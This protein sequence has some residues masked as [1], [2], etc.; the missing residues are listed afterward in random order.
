M[1]I[2]NYRS[3]VFNAAKLFLQAHVVKLFVDED[4]YNELHLLICQPPSGMHIIVHGNSSKYVCPLLCQCLWIFKLILLI[5]VLIAF[6]GQHICDGLLFN[7]KLK[8]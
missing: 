6:N 7:Y 1:I 3:P 4:I 8:V 2:I 5:L